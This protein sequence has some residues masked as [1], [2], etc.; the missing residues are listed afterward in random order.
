MFRRN[1]SIDRMTPSQAV[2]FDGMVATSVVT[3][4]VLLGNSYLNWSIDSSM[5]PFG[6]R[7]S[8]I[9]PVALWA[10]VTL[11]FAVAASFAR[12]RGFR[13]ALRDL[14][15]SLFLLG[16]LVLAIIVRKGE[17]TSDVLSTWVIIGGVVVL[18]LSINQIWSG[19]RHYWSADAVMPTGA[20]TSSPMSIPAGGNVTLRWSSVN[21]VSAQIN[22]V[23]TVPVNGTTVVTPAG[24]AGESV[25][26]TLTLRSADGT[27]ATFD[28][29][30]QLT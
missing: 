10:L 30:I 24:R 28:T 26:Y 9:V 17:Y 12:P 6:N 25:T 11:T 21:A 15:W 2:I 16:C 19:I 18:D 8:N 23:G 7:L 29:V 1:R 20:F 3:G 22:G 13:W 14:F 5:L 27:A 4:I